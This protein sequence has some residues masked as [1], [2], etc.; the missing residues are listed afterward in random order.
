MFPNY[1]TTENSEKSGITTPQVNN[2]L[3]SREI[4]Q[5]SH[6]YFYFILCQGV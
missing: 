5:H 1:V 6:V 3:A 2:S 4:K